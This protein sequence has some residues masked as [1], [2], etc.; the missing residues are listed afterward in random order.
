MSSRESTVG[1]AH[2]VAGT[3][4]DFTIGTRRHTGPSCHVSHL[5]VAGTKFDTVFPN[6]PRTLGTRV[7]EGIGSQQLPVGRTL[8]I[9][10]AASPHGR[11]GKGIS[12]LGIQTF[13]NQ[14]HMPTRGIAITDVP[15]QVQC[16][17]KQGN[18]ITLR[19][20]CDRIGRPE[21]TP[22]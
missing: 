14:I 21:H 12:A 5:I 17:T 1:L 18:R 13:Q 10:L 3:N 20:D 4:D 11:P 9:T 7:S 19:I 16:L 6:L 15:I 22:G 8:G 2:R